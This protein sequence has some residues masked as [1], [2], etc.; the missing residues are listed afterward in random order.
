MTKILIVSTSAATLKDHPTGL[1]IEEIA[2]PYYLF[3]DAGYEITIASTAGG[4]I[5]I[6]AGSMADMFFTEAAKKFMHDAAAIGALSHSVKLADIVDSVTEK[7]DGLFLP[8]G[9][10]TCT[11][12]VDDANVKKAIESMFNAGKL[13]SAVCHGPVALAQ[14]V[15]A[16]GKPLVEGK[17]VSCF[18]DSEEKAVKSEALVPFLLE[19]KLKELG[20]TINTGADW[21]DVTSADGNLVTGQ[22]PSSSKSVGEKVVEFFKSSS[23]SGSD[24]PAASVEF[25]TPP[26]AYMT[27][28]DDAA[29][30]KDAPSIDSVEYVKGDPIKLGDGKVSVVTFFAKFAKGDYTTVVGVSKLA[31]AFPDVQFL[32]I[33]VDPAKGDA[34]GF[35]K[36]IGTSMPEIYVASLDVNYPLAWDAGK[37]VKEEYRKA[38][39]M[40]AL[41]A[42]ACFV[43][44]GSGK[45]VWREQFGQGHPPSKGQLGEQIRRAVAGEEL[46]K[47]GP[48]PKTE[49]DDEEEEEMEMGGDDDYDSDLG[50]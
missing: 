28:E 40:M 16:D 19:S 22:N 12:F 41:G 43:V 46:L 1:W 5:P 8:G 18:T 47:N 26:E 44:D 42:S 48:K 14:C 49:E 13:V 20:A 29:I 39:G 25:A 24:A 3:K 36:K 34:E 10:G 17:T 7:F 4:A 15:R 9:H 37:A 21:A 31:D 23:G 45:I 11:D 32:G 33:S 6:D 50:F 27:Y 2:S 38:A 30:G 35:L